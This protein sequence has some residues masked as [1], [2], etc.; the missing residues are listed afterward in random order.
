MNIWL[1]T[2][3][4]PVPTLDARADRLHRTGFL[5]HFLAEHGHD[6]VWWTSTFNHFSKKHLYRCDTDVQIN[7]QLRI[8]LLHGCGYKSNISIARFKDHNQIAKKFK[9]LALKQ[10][11]QPD[12]IV[13]ALPTIELCLEVVRYCKTT[14]VPSVLDMRDMWPDIFIDSVPKILR[15][16]AGLFLGSMFR[17]AYVACSGATALT[18]I[19]DAFVDWGLKRGKRLKSDIDKAFHMGYI[20][21]AP[22]QKK[23]TIAEKYWNGKG[24]NPSKNEF[25]VC[26]FGTIGRQFDM[27]T[28]IRTAR[29]LEKQRKTVRFVICGTGDRLEYY[30]KQAAGVSNLIFPGWVD[31]AQIYVLM[32]W[33]AVGLDPLIDRYDFLATINNKAIEYMSAGLPIISS[34]DRGVLCDLLS[35]HK[36]G[37]SYPQ[38]DADTLSDILIK[39]HDDLDMLH[40]MSKKSIQLFNEQFTAEKVYGEMMA[41][42][43]K[44]AEKGKVGRA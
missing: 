15:P 37:V 35:R 44:I 28:V 3:G 13:A 38:G 12:I 33:A 9:K 1:V 34:P 39:T 36:C 11:K 31:A 4:E 5:A 18:G 8:K 21:A 19:T 25:I 14:G 24:I 43:V 16:I 41:H 7:D 29:K 40:E 6:V 26:F 30:K 32:R 23:I 20:T 22:N 17:S 10:T 2:I 27:D 42:L